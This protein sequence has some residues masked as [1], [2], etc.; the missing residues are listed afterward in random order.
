MSRPNQ[1]RNIGLGNNNNGNNMR[2]IPAPTSAIGAKG[3]PLT[4]IADLRPMM[5]GFNTECIL[6][7]KGKV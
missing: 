7:E 4:H 3:L 1:G 2:P 5:R 6:L